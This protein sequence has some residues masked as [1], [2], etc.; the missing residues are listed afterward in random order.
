MSE[1][2]RTRLVGRIAL[3]CVGVLIGVLVLSPVAAHV[4][5]T[6]GHL[7][8]NHVKPKSDK[9]YVNVNGD[10]MKKRLRVP[11]VTY[12]KPRKHILNISHYSLVPAD[13]TDPLRRSDGFGTSGDSGSDDLFGNVTLPDGARITK[14]AAVFHDTSAADTV[15]CLLRFGPRDNGSVDGVAFVDSEGSGGFQ[16]VETENIDDPAVVKN[17]L[18]FYYLQCGAISG[19]WSGTTLTVKGVMIH[20]TLPAAP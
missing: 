1:S 20:Y 16:L 19:N 13:E 15:R 4:S 9:R 12:T 18:G 2:R 14:L 7:W 10:T 8:N 11:K 6:F 5:S 3:L 17:G